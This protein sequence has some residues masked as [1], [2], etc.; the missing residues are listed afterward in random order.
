MP[1]AYN[2]WVQ[3]MQSEENDL[4]NTIQGSIPSFPVLYFSWTPPN[5]ILQFQK[6][7]PAGKVIS[8]FSQW[9]KNTQQWVSRP[10]VQEYTVVIPTK[11]KDFNCC[12]DCVHGFIRIVKQINSTH[13]VSSGAVFVPAHLVGENAASGGIDSVWLVNDHV[14]L[15]TSSATTLVSV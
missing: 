13:I 8:T 9:C 14:E 11:Y 5:Q 10:Q 7:L 3:Y 12:A 15:N 2:I 4:D 1:E 6:R